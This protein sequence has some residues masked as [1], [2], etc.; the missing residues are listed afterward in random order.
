[1]DLNVVVVTGRLVSAVER[2]VGQSGRVLTELRLGIARPSRKGEAEQ[3]T[4][5][6]ITIWAGDVGAAV[7][8]L[9]EG[10]RL[11][12][13]GRVSAREWNTRLYVEV[14]ADAVTMAVAAGPGEPAVPAAGSA[15]E[16]PF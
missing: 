12:V 9:P 3:P 16:L 7:R 15:E 1:V 6:P 5:V 14:I 4:V 10:T 8:D 13:V 11:T 2:A